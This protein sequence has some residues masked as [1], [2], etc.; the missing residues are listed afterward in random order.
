MCITNYDT[1]VIQNPNSICVCMPHSAPSQPPRNLQRVPLNSTTLRLSW[2]PPS[3]QYQ[4]GL[5]REYRINITENETGRNFQLTSTHT[6]I[7]IPHLH[8]YYQYNCSVAA[9][10][11]S[12][13]PF[14]SA[15][16]VSMPENGNNCVLYIHVPIPCCSLDSTRNIYPL[17]FAVPS[18]PP[19]NLQASATSSSSVSLTWDV[20]LPEYQ[21]GMITNYTV[22]VTPV[23]PQS[24]PYQLNTTNKSTRLLVTS[25]EEF[26][27][28][29]FVVAARTRVGVGPF[30]TSITV[31]THTD[32]KE[33]CW[34]AWSIAMLLKM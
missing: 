7:I 26:S 18:G 11:I 9:Y 13:G 31:Q 24:D 1:E 2:Q 19:R 4:N 15:I 34:T 8:P 25:L 20:P 30:S 27:S 32:G 21:N 28:Y 29:T 3:S 23:N 16:T 14:S 6:F 5:I 17:P 33:T 10:T 12:L 22:L